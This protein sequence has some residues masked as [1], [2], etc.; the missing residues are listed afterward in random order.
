M[1]I[2]ELAQ[3]AGVTTQT[4]RF[5]EREGLLPEPTRS[6][7][8]YREYAPEWIDEILFIRECGESGFTLGEIK[9]LKGLD[10][11]RSSSCAEMGGLLRRKLRAID[12]KIATLQRVRDH[13]SVLEQSC[14]GNRSGKPCPVLSEMRS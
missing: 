7:N 14:S 11:D 13:L 2:G 5:Y 6:A 4:I 12:D 3:A 10:A 9:K 1:K 8:G